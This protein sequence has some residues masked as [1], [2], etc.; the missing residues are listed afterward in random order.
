MGT[1]RTGEAVGGKRD[2]VAHRMFSANG[3]HSRDGVVVVVVI[4][5][6]QRGREQGVGGTKDVRR[7]KNINK[8]G[9]RVVICVGYGIFV[10]NMVDN[11]EVNF[12]LW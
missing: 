12:N 11:V 2:P 3:D 9:R 5:V 8:K 7:S 6:A 1:I 4:T 10:R